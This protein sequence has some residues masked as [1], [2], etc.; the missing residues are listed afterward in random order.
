[1]HF[2]AQTQWPHVGPDRFDMGQTLLFGAGFSR[3]FPSGRILAVSRPDRILFLVIYDDLVDRFV[4]LFVH[5]SR[6]A[7]WFDAVK[8]EWSERQDLNLRRLGPKPSALARLSYAPTPRGRNI[9]GMTLGR[10]DY[11]SGINISFL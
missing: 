8:I 11:L 10:N 4:V 6:F 7:A 5:R 3:V 9:Y 1:M 2:F